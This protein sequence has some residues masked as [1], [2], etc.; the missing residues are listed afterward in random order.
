MRGGAAADVS[1]MR[2]SGGVA[3]EAIVVVE[4]AEDRYYVSGPMTEEGELVS[5]KMAEVWA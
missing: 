3:E 1:W 5:R 4:A 2:F